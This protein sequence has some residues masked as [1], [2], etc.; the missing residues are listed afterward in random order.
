MKRHPALVPLSRQHHDGLALGVF[1]DRDLR[2]D[3]NPAAA[4]RLRVKV[5][6]AWELELNGHFAVEEEILFP[7]A[8]EAIEDKGVVDRLVREHAEIRTA[9]AEL[10]SVA[11]GTLV[12]RLRSLR[13][14]LVA[15]IRY[16]ERILFE[17]VQNSLSEESLQ[18]LGKRIDKALPRACVHLGS[19]DMS[20]RPSGR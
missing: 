8:R 16:E 19:A 4:E 7:V 13:E 11:G 6:A 9:I 14:I 18:R 5:A 3:P 2:G 10:Q 1:I 20:G 17:A 15:H 12:R